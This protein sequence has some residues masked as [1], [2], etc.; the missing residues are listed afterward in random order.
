MEGR[1]EREDGERA[2]SR[3]VPVDTD[4][5]LHA[6]G[7]VVREDRSLH[8]SDWDTHSGGS[9]QVRVPC[10]VG[11]FDVVETILLLSCLPKDVSLFCT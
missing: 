10:A 11:H 1:G 4:V 9:D 6:V 8:W 3:G 2:A 7:R 5:S